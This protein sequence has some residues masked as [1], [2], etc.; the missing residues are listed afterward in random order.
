MFRTVES[1]M[2]L[3]GH[4]QCAGRRRVSVCARIGKSLTGFVLGLVGDGFGLVPNE[5]T[6]TLMGW[7]LTEVR[8]C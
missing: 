3:T 7:Y 4:K 1:Q 6:L 2:I 5:G 8:L